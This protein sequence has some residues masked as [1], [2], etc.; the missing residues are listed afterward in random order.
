[1]TYSRILAFFL[2]LLPI[3]ATVDG[4]AMAPL[5]VAL[6][7]LLVCR[8]SLFPIGKP[9]LTLFALLAVWPVLTSIWS[10]IALTSLSTSLRSAGFLFAALL[11]A[12]AV[13]APDDKAW[14]AL[15]IGTVLASLLI[16]LELFPGGGLLLRMAVAVHGEN[17]GTYMWKD[18]NKGLCALSALVWAAVIGLLACNR[19]KAALLLPWLV[20]PALLS[21]HSLS[22]KTGWIAGMVTF[23][24]A[25]LL[26]NVTRRA[27]TY[28]I[29]LAFIVWPLAFYFA[30]P[31]IR[32]HF[33]E[34]LP[35]SSQHRVEIWHFVL[36]KWQER[37]LLGW[38]VDSSR[39]IPGGLDEVRPN[40]VGLPLH[41]HNMPLHI[42]L[43]QGIIGFA[44]F[45]VALCIV[46]RGVWRVAPGQPYMTA[47]IAAALSCYL[48][49][50]MSAFGMWQTWWVAT[51]LSV[52]VLA[53][54]AVRRAQTADC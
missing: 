36:Q 35:P 27:L 12:H 20:L 42:L 7:L 45:F 38:G 15:A 54:A 21:M 43:E 23:Y 19:R 41:P 8:K 17:G 5:F 39:S 30:E 11:A 3:V 16:L 10:I 40:M 4:L 6:W 37:P 24:A 47:A 2:V 29:P 49:I 33:Y 26:P 44:L 51:G 34:Q 48:T 25:I 52:Y 32:Q 18:I 1:M 53:R 46:V 9:A 31:M 14:Q 50:A 22:S 13:R 28:G